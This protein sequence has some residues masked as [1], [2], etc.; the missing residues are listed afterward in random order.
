[1]NHLLVF[2]LDTKPYL[3]DIGN[4]CAGMSRSGADVGNG[5]LRG[6]CSRGFP[7]GLEFSLQF[8]NG[9]CLYP[10]N[11]QASLGAKLVAAVDICRTDLS[12]YTISNTGNLRH[13]KTGFCVQPEEDDVDVPLILGK[14]CDRK[15]AFS[16]TVN[17]SL[18]VEEG[19]K[20]VQSATGSTRPS[21]AENFVLRHA[22]DLQESQFTIFTGTS[23]NCGIFVVYSTALNEFSEVIQEFSRY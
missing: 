17:G 4:D 16:M 12:K 7:N 10:E 22:C 9:R 23:C 19:G 14:G 11:N 18:Q 15:W 3:G 5:E 8:V 21:D 20:C 1:M 13:V 2:P 6:G